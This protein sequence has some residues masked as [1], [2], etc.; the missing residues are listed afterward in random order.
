MGAF[1]FGSLWKKLEMLAKQTF[2]LK[3]KRIPFKEN[4]ALMTRFG[5]H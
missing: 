2:G 5:K 4:N 3:S 1:S